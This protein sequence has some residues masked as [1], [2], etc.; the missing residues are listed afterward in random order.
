MLEVYE[1]YVGL[2]IRTVILAVNEDPIDGFLVFYTRLS[3]G[4]LFYRELVR[5]PSKEVLARGELHTALKLNVATGMG[6]KLVY[7]VHLVTE[8]APS[9]IFFRLVDGESSGYRQNAIQLGLNFGF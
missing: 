4:G 3:V 8:W 2:G 9:F 7:G 6:I 1:H 5:G